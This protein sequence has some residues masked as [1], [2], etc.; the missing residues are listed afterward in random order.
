MFY[1]LV[2]ILRA[3]A[4]TLVMVYHVIALGEWSIFN[5]PLWAFPFRSG[6]IGVDLFLV[7]SG[8]VITLSAAVERQKNP[9]AFR[10]SF[11]Q[12]RLRRL[13]PLY[14]LTCVVYVFLVRPEILSRPTHEIILLVASHALFLQ[15]LSP[16]T[17]GAINGVSWSLALEMQFYLALIMSIGLL[18]K[19]GTWRTLVLLVGIAW[20]W[21]FGTTFFLKP[22]EAIAHLQVIYTTELPGTLD[23]FGVGV[24]MALFVF[25]CQGQ[26]KGVFTR[27]W[28]HCLIWAGASLGLLWLSGRLIMSHSNYWSHLGMIVFWRTLLA[29][30]FAAAL[31]AVITCPLR[32]GG[33]LRPLQYMGQ[34]S[35]G[36]YLWH[37][38]VLLV[39]VTRPDMRGGRLFVFVLVGSFLL[40]S[41]T[42]HLMEK[43]WLQRA[44]PANPSHN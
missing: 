29:L 39:L 22:G 42:W 8:F 5:E 26:S 10:W 23:T 3:V 17:H 13:V 12:R 34:I 21:R 18:L 20:A 35:Y 41:L 44:L 4:V 7:I 43:H 37:F 24:A 1:P 30:G 19:L 2:D 40:A 31:A 15:N 28:L 9:D 33:L 38:P 6:W 36:L 11:M 14:V 25:K 32:G 27:G 16:L